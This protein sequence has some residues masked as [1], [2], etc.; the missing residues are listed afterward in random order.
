[1]STSESKSR[2]NLSLFDFP[3]PIELLQEVF[4]YLDFQSLLLSRCVDSYFRTL[5][6]DLLQ[7]RQIRVVVNSAVK[8]SQKT[9]GY[10]L[11]REHTRSIAEFCWGKPACSKIT[12]CAL[13]VRTTLSQ[14]ANGV[15]LTKSLDHGQR[16]KLQKMKEMVDDLATTAKMHT[17]PGALCTKGLL[18]AEYDALIVDCLVAILKIVKD[19]AFRLVV[20]VPPNE[21]ACESVRRCLYMGT[22]AE[23]EI[24]LK[25][26]LRIALNTR[27]DVNVG[28]CVV[29]RGS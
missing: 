24:W 12:L 6:E 28:R 16:S 19:V 21:I 9:W 13:I 22:D 4:L 7:Y 10:S 18:R 3:L 2:I 14:V 27:I 23:A 8:F 17:A 15:E 20:S 25:Q 1:M 5:I 29:C 11:L 26:L